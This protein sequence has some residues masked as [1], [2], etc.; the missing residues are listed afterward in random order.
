MSFMQRL[1]GA[2][3]PIALETKSAGPGS[4]A[5]VSR[6]LEGIGRAFEEFKDKH[7]RELAELKRGRP[8]PLTA[9]QVDKINKNISDIERTMEQEILALKRNAIFS[10][11]AD[12][13]E[14]KS[15]EAMDYETAF[16]KYIRKGG[17]TAKLELERLG[18]TVP[19]L[20]ALSVGSDPDGGFTVLPQVERTMVELSLLISPIRQVA[21]VTQIGN[22]ALKIPV[23]VRG[24]TA[25]WVGEP[26]AR[27]ETTASS[28]K[29][30]EIPVN[31]IYCMPAA[32]QSMLDDSYLNV[33]QWI[34]NEAAMIFAQMEGQAFVSGTGLTKPRGF[35]T[36][37]VV[38]DA[39]WAWQK[40]GYYP[41]GASGAFDTTLTFNP[42]I[43][44]IYGLRG[45]YRAN[46]VWLANRRTIAAARKMKDTTG[47]YLWQP[48][49][50]AGQPATLGGHA[51]HDTENMPDMASNSYSMLFGDMKQFYRIVDRIGIRTLRDPYSSK[52]Y[53]LFY[54]TK[55]VGG[56]VQNFEAAKLLK[57][58]AS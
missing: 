54:T 53:V 44:I 52:P 10:R 8:D 18:E 25:G 20:K 47:Q 26:A 37:D 36:E 31:E 1:T 38:A 56:A 29:E 58:A 9:E 27:T 41:S 34:A 6:S 39:S 21:A 49:V 51:V 24:A 14:Y 55:R 22:S 40:I 5:E 19:E 45:I 23:N 57:F 17:D 35:L 13:G 42:L 4:M 16:A 46:A 50:A 12:G 3:S 33:E 28:F 7:T 2:C 32:T 11:M 43:D 15:R 48:A 30:I